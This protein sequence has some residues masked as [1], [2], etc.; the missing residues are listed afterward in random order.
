MTH[1]VEAGSSSG[2]TNLTSGELQAEIVEGFLNQV[3]VLVSD[4]AEFD[5]R[6]AYEENTAGRMTIASGF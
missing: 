3:R 6:N 5:G 4:V 1:G 2:V